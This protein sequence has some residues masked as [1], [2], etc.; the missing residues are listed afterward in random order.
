MLSGHLTS[1]SLLSILQIWE[2]QVPFKFSSSYK[3]K[4][5]IDQGK[6]QLKQ[7][8]LTWNEMVFH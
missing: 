8:Q 1:Q 5:K 7:S 3:K 6:L 2:W 4:K